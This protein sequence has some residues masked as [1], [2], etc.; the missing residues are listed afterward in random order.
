MNAAPYWLMNAAVLCCLRF[1]RY[2]SATVDNFVYKLCLIIDIFCRFLVYQII[3]PFVIPVF[4][5]YIDRL[6]LY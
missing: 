5:M 3:M 2:F 1:V 6:G 4:L